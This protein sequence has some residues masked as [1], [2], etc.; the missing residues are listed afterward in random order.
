MDYTVDEA[1]AFDAS[2]K[3]LP[4]EEGGE[5]PME[6]AKQKITLILGVTGFF[7]VATVVIS[8]LCLFFTIRFCFGANIF[9]D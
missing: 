9:K 2:L 7:V 5:D 8:T 3:S 6:A 1:K 4:P